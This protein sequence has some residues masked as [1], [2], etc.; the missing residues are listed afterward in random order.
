MGLLGGYSSEEEEDEAAKPAEAGTG[1]ATASQTSKAASDEEASDEED[2]EPATKRQRGVSSANPL[3]LLPPKL[4]IFGE[5]PDAG[6]KKIAAATA[7]VP[8]QVRKTGRV[9]STV[10]D[11]ISDRSFATSK[12]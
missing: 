1:G 7:F 2:D 4:S 6:K 10:T 9:V 5:A 11:N 12:Q 8:P 3:G